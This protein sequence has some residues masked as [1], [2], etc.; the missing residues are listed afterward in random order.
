MTP[1]AR[2]TAGLLLAI[3]VVSVGYLFQQTTA[4]PDE[5]L[6]GAEPLSNS[7][8]VAIEAAISQAGLADFQTDGNRIRV[9]RG[10]KDLYIAA[11]AD[12][13]ALPQSVMGYRQD[14]LKNGGM[15][16]SR[17]VKMQRD[18]AAREQQ[19]SHIIT[20]MPWVSQASVMYEEKERGGLRSRQDVAAS[21]AVTPLPGET[22]DS[23][24][25]RR[26]QRMVA[27]WHPSLKAENVTITNTGGDE[28]FAGSG[29]IEADDFE[30]PYYRARVRYEQYMQSKIARQLGR[31]GGVRVQV[32]AVLDEV[33]RTETFDLK[34]D[35]NALQEQV[36]TTEKEKTSK[37]TDGMGRPGLQ[38]NGPGRNRDEGPDRLNEMRDFI[39]TEDSSRVTG[40]TKTQ[41]TKTGLTPKEVWASVGIPRDFVID[42]WKKQKLATD[43]TVPEK[44]N[45]QELR[46]FEEELK[47]SLQDEVQPLLPNLAAGQDDLKQVVVTVFDTVTPLP[48]EGPSMMSEAMAFTG[49]YGSTLGMLLLGGFSLLML[50]S[51]V[52][53]TPTGD[54]DPGTAGLRGLQL[55]MGSDAA[56]GASGTDDRDENGNARPKLKI[57]KAETLKDDLVEM[58]REDPDAAA[59]ILRTWIGNAS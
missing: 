51:V 54:D 15:F 37:L 39:K 6:F 9:P 20:L 12:G 57:A 30:D 16:D 23:R 56:G 14:S 25:A 24:R 42:L 43:G 34:P 1:G 58:V 27:G 40:H 8:I 45:L 48:I 13:D 21:V 18:R 47:S 17:E 36:T 7:Q 49:R 55:D 19:L 11:I 32:N 33:L 22:L 29:D 10:K 46:T 28:T 4:G 2:I 38:A 35:Q 3:V 5:Y 50:R 53:G 52:R 26:L 59:A 44:I 41:V 31:I